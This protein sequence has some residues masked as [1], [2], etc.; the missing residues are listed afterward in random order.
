LAILLLSLLASSVKAKEKVNV[1]VYHLKPPFIVDNINKQ[2]LYFDF[3]TYLNQKSQKYSFET[4]FVPRKRIETMLNQS[5]LDGILVGV[6]PIWFKDKNETKYLWTDKIYH[7]QDEIVSLQS[8]QVE[9]KNPK[10]LSGKFLAGVRGFYYFGIDELV[11]QGEIKRFDT[12][13]EH[14]VLQMIDLKRVEVGIVSRSTLNYLLKNNTWQHEFYLSKQPHDNY[15]RRI[16]VPHYNLDIYQ[17]IA[18]IIQLM[19]TDPAWNKMLSKY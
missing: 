9:Y 11:S 18:P 4:I 14:E 6:N 17:E 10:S 12:I 8:T 13:G 5:K 1:Y 16:L 15:Q 2:G 7:D 3:S 19:G